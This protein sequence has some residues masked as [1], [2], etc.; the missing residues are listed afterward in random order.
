MSWG[1]L[2]AWLKRPPALSAGGWHALPGKGPEARADLDRL[3]MVGQAASRAWL[4]GR[5]GRVGA[6]L[7]IYP[8]CLNL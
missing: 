5:A 4:G 8:I 1:M 7:S 6:C 2:H 3:V